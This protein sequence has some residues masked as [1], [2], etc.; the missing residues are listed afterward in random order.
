MEK[1]AVVKSSPDEKLIAFAVG[2]GCCARGCFEY[3]VKVG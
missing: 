3:P 2:A 1:V